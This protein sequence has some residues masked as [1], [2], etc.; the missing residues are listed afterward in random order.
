[1]REGG[2]EREGV[3]CVC[4]LCV[5][6]CLGDAVPPPAGHLHAHDQAARLPGHLPRVCVCV[7]GGGDT[8]S[9][10]VCVYGYMCV[11]VCVSYGSLTWICGT[12]RCST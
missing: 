11:C 8:P 3:P 1:M 4:G 6:V 7:L 2:G 10:S 12:A 9:L 5:F